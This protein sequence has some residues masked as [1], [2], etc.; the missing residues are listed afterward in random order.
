[1]V[2]HH[3]IPDDVKEA[4]RRGLALKAAGYA[5]GTPTG[6]GQNS[7]SEIHTSIQARWP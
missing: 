4:A 3:R 5:G 1:M 6:W 7:S 2:T